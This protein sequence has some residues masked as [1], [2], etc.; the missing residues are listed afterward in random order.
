MQGVRLRMEIRT[1]E[2][3]NALED[4]D[5]NSVLAELKKEERIVN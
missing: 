5:D 3:Q 1:A 2:T 4:E